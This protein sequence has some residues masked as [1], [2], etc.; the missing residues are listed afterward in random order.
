MTNSEFLAS[1]IAQTLDSLSEASATG[2]ET[3]EHELEVD[4]IDLVE[5]LKKEGYSVTPPEPSKADLEAAKRNEIAQVIGNALIWAEKPP[6][7]ALQGLRVSI[8]RAEYNPSQNVI[9]LV[10]EK[11]LAIVGS[12]P[13][14]E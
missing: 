9:T 12:E 7:I 1:A 11:T 13:L 10:P 2:P 14:E 8:Q 5:I 4:I 3:C 6:R